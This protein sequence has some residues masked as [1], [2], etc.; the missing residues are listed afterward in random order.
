M[1]FLSA[2][3]DRVKPSATLLAM[4]QARELRKTGARILALTTGEP[5]FDT[6]D[7]IKQAAIEAINRGETKYPPVS[8]IEPL[9]LAIIEKFKKENQLDY[10]L[11]QVM[12]SNGGKQVIFNALLATINPGDEVIIPTP[13]WVSYPEM[14]HLVGGTPVF[15]HTTLENNF[16]LRAEDLEKV[17]TPKTKWLIFNSPS[18]PSGACYNIDELAA[19]AEVLKK[20]PQVYI[21]SDDIYEHLIYDDVKFATLAQLDSELYERTLTM[22]GVSKSYAMTG[23]RIGYAGGPKNLIK[24]METLQGQ[25]TSGA[26]SIAQW[27]AVAALTGSQACIKDFQASFK[28]RRDLVVKML[29]EAAGLECPIPEGAFYVFPSCASLIG[30]VTPNGERIDTDIDFVSQLLKSTGVALVQGSA[31]GL[32]PNFRLSYATSD[33]ILLEACTKIQEFCASLR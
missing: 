33:E 20:H 9:K 5:D 11:N 19:L 21:L 18:N 1:P 23:W 13:F 26:C 24:A 25:Q 28:R 4:H 14:V 30:K 2:I 32:G 22:N 12:V 8:G 7:H 3:L 27:A 6:P 16:K 10:D 29:N 31:F 17:I 15:A